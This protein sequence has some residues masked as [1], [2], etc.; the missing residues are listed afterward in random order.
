MKPYIC[1]NDHN[2]VYGHRT[3]GLPYDHYT[4]DSIA[5]ATVAVLLL[6]AGISFFPHVIVSVEGS[7]GDVFFMGI[8]FYFRG[9]TIP[10]KGS[11]KPAHGLLVRWPVTERD[12]Y[13]A[14]SLYRNGNIHCTLVTPR[15]ITMWKREGII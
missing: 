5:E 10:L 2:R 13:E 14:A 4:Y 11:E 3:I 6:K 12:C 8:S 9:V 7:H 15:T 1:P